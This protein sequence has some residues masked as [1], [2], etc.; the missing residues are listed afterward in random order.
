M[1]KLGYMGQTGLQTSQAW[2]K[3]GLRGLPGSCHVGHVGHVGLVGHWARKC[4]KWLLGLQEF[5]GKCFWA[6]GLK[7][8]CLGL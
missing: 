3:N 7:S 1:N 2:V 6:I 8:G 4:A 5:M